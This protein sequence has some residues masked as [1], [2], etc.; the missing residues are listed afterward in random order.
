MRESLRTLI[1]QYPRCANAVLAVTSI[2][3]VL[4]ILE[5]GFRAAVR[6]YN[7]TEAD[8]LALFAHKALTEDTLRYYDPHPYLS[9]APNHIQ[10]MP[11]G[12]R[13]RENRFPYRKKPK[14]I[15]IACVGGSTTMNQFPPML[16]II[17]NRRPVDRRFEVMDFGSSAWNS[18]ES[19]INFLIR[20]ADFQPDVVLAH[21][22]I[23]DYPPRVWPNYRPDYS[24]FRKTWH[25][26]WF[27]DFARNYLSYS[28][29]I[30]HLLRR[31]GMSYYD[32]QNRT[33]HRV[34]PSE[35]N[36]DLQPETLRA[37]E[38]NLRMLHAM[39]S[40]Y[41]GRL[42]LAPMA[43]L[44]TVDSPNEKKGIEECNQIMRAVARDL[45][46]PLAETDEFL[47]ERPEWFKDIVHLYP[48]GNHLKAQLY[49]YTILKTVGMLDREDLVSTGGDYK[50]TRQILAEGRDLEVTWNFDPSLVRE[51]QIHVR[52]DQEQEFRYLGR[53]GSPSVQTLRWKAGFTNLELPIK[54]EFQSGPKWG[55][56]YYFKIGA[57][58]NDDPPRVIDQLFS[59]REV[60]VLE[61]Y[62]F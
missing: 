8:L 61:R 4:L 58:G 41:G 44:R 50:T 49:A 36:P 40:S 31:I 42:I 27:G 51:F 24:H 2:L 45:Q 55:H 17:L 12:I 30:S 29:M 47:R 20:V 59:G 22:G 34:D 1:R 28:W 43:Y 9:F 5:I 62:H 6:W 32:L 37:Y 56:Y 54:D 3:A 52:I 48:N 13:I 39:V 46:V 57:I 18:T 35:L 38:R 19:T 10:Y 53:T 25:E 11:E 23:N 60:K 14:T 33:T 7:P 21:H 15:R 16:F 26:G